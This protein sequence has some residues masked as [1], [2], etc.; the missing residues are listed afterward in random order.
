MGNQYL[1]DRTTEK[2]EKQETVLQSRF[3]Y[4]ITISVIFIFEGGEFSWKKKNFDL[5]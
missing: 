1:K 4:F 3:I 2:R 5:T